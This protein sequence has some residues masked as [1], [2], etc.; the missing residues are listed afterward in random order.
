MVKSISSD[1]FAALGRRVSEV[2]TRRGWTQA[3][4]ATRADISVAF[5]S[6]IENGKRNVSSEK[7][8]QL[9]NAL[10]VS[11]DFL[12]RGND[13]NAQP[14]SVAVS[15]PAALAEAAER[16]GWSYSQTVALLQTRR[17]VL[18][19]RSPGGE[20]EASSDNYEAADWTRFYTRVFAED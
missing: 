17:L 4:L 19:K 9:A 14:R 1:T 6:D 15:I 2:R 20:A 7:L 11:L 18:A 10:R 3:D 8:L 12:V 16:E 5:L 13:A